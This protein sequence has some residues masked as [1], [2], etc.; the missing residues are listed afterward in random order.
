MLDERVA[1]NFCCSLKNASMY[2]NNSLQLGFICAKNLS[3]LE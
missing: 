3:S 2:R 1:A